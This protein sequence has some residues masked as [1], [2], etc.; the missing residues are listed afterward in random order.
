MDEP[1]RY[2]LVISSSRYSDPSLRQLSSPT[3]D[4]DALA[5]LLRDK[6]VGGFR[7]RPVVDQ[8]SWV[9]SEEIERFFTARRLADVTLVYFSGH[10]IKDEDGTLYFAAMNTVPTLL[11]STSVPSA[12][13]ASAMRKCRSRRQ[14]LLLDC[15]YAG[16]FSRAML[17]KSDPRVGIQER[18]ASEGAGRVVIAASDTMQVALEGGE[19]KGVPA[20]SIFTHAVVDGIRTGAAD[21]DGDGNISLDELYDY[22]YERVRQNDPDQT[23]T[24]SNVEKRGDIVI[25][26]NPRAGQSGKQGTHD[27]EPKNG[28]PP[29]PPPPDD[30]DDA[31]DD[32]GQ[33]DDKP[34][35]P[36]WLPARVGAG[37]AV[38]AVVGLIA[39][40]IL[41]DGTTDSWSSLDAASA[42]VAGPPT[43][44]LRAIAAHGTTEAVAVGSSGREPGVWS[45]DGTRWSKD[46][47]PVMQG[48]S[49][50]LN[51]VASSRGTVV[52]TGSISHSAEEGA[53]AAIWVRVGGEWTSNVCRGSGCRD[54][55]KQEV[56]AVVPR[57]DAGGFVAVG[58]DDSGGRFEAAVW[59]SDDG[60]DWERAADDGQLGGEG[61]QAMKGVVDLGGR[62][63]A[64]GRSGPEGAVWASDDGT[65]WDLVTQPFRARDGNV[66]LEEIA[67]GDGV[68][69]AVGREYSRQDEQNEAAAWFSDD[70]GVQWTRASIQN[71]RFTGQQMVDVI[72]TPVGF[73]AVGFDR[74]DGGGQNAAA[75]R[76]PDG[77]AW[78]VDASGSFGDGQPVMR[79]VASLSSGL[80]AVGDARDESEDARNGRIWFSEPES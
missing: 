75:W 80:F 46:D 8:P 36:E 22:V 9:V 69:V 55:G 31:D 58:R 62:L 10:G 3:A 79:G 4:A 76:S 26:L 74:R 27:Q 61:D 23:P 68:V 11:G 14:V 19:V 63:L 53:N 44:V 66:E 17:A 47:P 64:V 1:D 6:D 25:A 65:E 33:G 54:S 12:H 48:R 52:A 49:G 50:D 34:T 15:C 67:F 35:L 13:I 57:L 40:L 29:P 60:L 41:R 43:Q 20:L 73:V 70:R 77:R 16:A 39:F 30:T 18:F 42:N 56:L 5:E 51:A 32:G 45:Y 21:L 2:A 71:A 72:R 24:I 38:V 59:L 78:T 37:I 7:V 28:S